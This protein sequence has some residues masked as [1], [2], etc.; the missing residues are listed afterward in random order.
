MDDATL[1]GYL[2]KHARPPAFGGPDG[3]SYSV[4]VMVE[5]QPDAEGRYG[6]ALLF[7]R[8]SE[9]GDAPAGH[10]ETDLLV[11]GRTREEAESAINALSLHDV[12]AHLD[13]AVAA[14]GQW[15]DW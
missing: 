5:D 6:A 14:R 13:R 4:A 1:G 12:K 2:T 15:P 9:A 7:V 3:R 10:A 11:H 8:W